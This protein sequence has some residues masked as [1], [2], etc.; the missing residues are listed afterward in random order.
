MVRGEVEIFV[1]E[2]EIFVEEVEMKMVEG[3]RNLGWKER[4]ERKEKRKKEKKL[5][6][7]NILL[8]EKMKLMEV[9]DSRD[10]VADAE[11]FR[12]NTG[13]VRNSSISV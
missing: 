2:V 5:K 6:R 1:E 12:E 10:S 7:E 4:K 3:W 11:I 8:E 9:A 13:I